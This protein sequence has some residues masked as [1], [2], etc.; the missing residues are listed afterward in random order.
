[1]FEEDCWTISPCLQVLD[2]DGNLW[3]IAVG[4]LP[5]NA[6]T[7]YS[8]KCNTRMLYRFNRTY[9]GYTGLSS[10]FRSDVSE[11]GHTL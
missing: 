10:A 8:R 4:D 5:K 9:S 7:D 11:T 3:Y 1:M 6:T 2:T